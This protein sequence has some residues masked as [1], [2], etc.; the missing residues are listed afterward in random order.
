MSGCNLEASSTQQGR[1]SFRIPAFDLNV[2]ALW[3]RVS[4]AHEINVLILVYRHNK[5][6]SL[7]DNFHTLQSRDVDSKYPEAMKH[8]NRRKQART[9]KR[10]PFKLVTLL[11]RPFANF[12]PRIFRSLPAYSAAQAMVQPDVRKLLASLRNNAASFVSGANPSFNG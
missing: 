12:N 7:A 10:R 9:L 5:P 1:G 11:A 6:K 8:L 4:K 3:W 2:G